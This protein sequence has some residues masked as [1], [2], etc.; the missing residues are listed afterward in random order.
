MPYV[1]PG[2]HLINPMPTYE[3]LDELVD[4]DPIKLRDVAIELAKEV[5]KLRNPVITIDDDWNCGRPEW[6]DGRCLPFAT[7]SDIAETT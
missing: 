4:T 2:P 3:Y 5:E 1:P 6:H 7:Q